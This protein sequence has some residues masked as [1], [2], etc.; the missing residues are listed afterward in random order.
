MKTQDS[1]LPLAIFH[2]IDYGSIRSY[3]SSSHY[4]TH[5]T[6]YL[7]AFLSHNPEQ[8]C[9][10]HPYFTAV[11]Y[12]TDSC[13]SWISPHSQALSGSIIQL[14]DWPLAPCGLDN[15]NSSSYIHLQAPLAC[16][17][18]TEIPTNPQPLH[19][20]TNITGRS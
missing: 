5:N 16:S 10:Y 6:V 19:S 9:H 8:F 17:V 18:L 7:Q 1:T 13:V 12:P 11:Y 2:Y 20:S 3:R 4:T 15:M 14:K